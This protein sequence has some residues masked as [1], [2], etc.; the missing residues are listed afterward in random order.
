MSTAR[1]PPQN[2]TKTSRKKNKKILSQTI[3][4]TFENC[5]VTNIFVLTTKAERVREID[6]VERESE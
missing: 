4:K 5:I 6:A 1:L 2:K 3:D